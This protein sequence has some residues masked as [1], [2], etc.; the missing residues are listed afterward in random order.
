MAKPKHGEYNP[1]FQGYM[2]LV[3]EGDLLLLL[4]E[5]TSQAIEFFNNIDPLKHNYKYADGKWSIKEVLM[6]IIDTERVFAYR[7]L[8]TIRGD[9]STL[10]S[11]DENHYAANVSVSSRT[12]ESLIDEFTIVRKSSELLY[13]NS[14]ETD[15][16]NECNL[17]PYKITANATGYFMIGHLNHHIEVIKDRYL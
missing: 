4:K 8:A 1:D 7:A 17:L 6:H 11:M 2:D 10:P 14:S 12:L 9:K 15:L 13:E 5:N 3:E 16:A